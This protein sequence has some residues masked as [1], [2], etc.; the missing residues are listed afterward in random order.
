MAYTKQNFEDGQVLTAEHLNNMEGGIAAPDW[1]Q[2]V[3]KPFGY[4]YGDTLTW[5]G[6]TEGLEVFNSAYY[7]VSDAAPTLSQI[8]A[9]GSLGVNGGIAP[10]ESD[11]FG[12]MD[13]VVYIGSTDMPL[14]FIVDKEDEFATGVS[15]GTYFM[16]FPA[17]DIVV[18]SLTINGY[19]EYLGKKQIDES[20]IPD[21]VKGSL[22]ILYADSDK[23][24][25]ARSDT[26]DTTK[27]ITKEELQNYF[28]SGHPMWIALSDD[29][30]YTTVTSVDLHT[31]RD[32]GIVYTV[33]PSLT[34]YY[35]AEY[36]A[37]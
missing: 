16:N 5:D 36:T 12:E 26:S 33:L 1:E 2:M 17:F 35:T 8:S 37:S 7:K 24:L 18:S 23:Y 34:D 25:Y 27:R 9:G 29:K 3:N 31:A 22:V 15:K 20:Y 4:V 21:S 10:I 30:Q 32:Y 11:F 19:T 28:S 6:N 13:G 14:I